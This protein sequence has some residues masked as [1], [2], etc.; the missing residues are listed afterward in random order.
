VGTL[1]GVRCNRALFARFPPLFTLSADPSG[2]ACAGLE[3][4]LNRFTCTRT[5]QAYVS[6][7]R[8]FASTL[9]DPNLPPMGMRVRL[10]ASVDISR[11]P[12]TAQVVLTALKRYGMLVADNGGNWFLSG[13]PDSRWNDAKIDT[14]KQIRGSDFE[15]VQMGPIVTQ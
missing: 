15:V 8:H 2:R 4:C 14:L 13:A 7:A 9:T 5:R 11:Y 10:N 12:A 3:N 6:P 1:R